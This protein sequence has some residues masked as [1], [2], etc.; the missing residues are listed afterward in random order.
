MA[1]DTFD[2]PIPPSPGTKRK[3]R[4]RLLEVEFGDGY[5]QTTR[6]GLNHIRRTLSL[7]WEL[8]TP[9]QAAEITDFLEE[10]GGDIPF[11]YQPSDDPAPLQWRCKDW[12]D[13][14][15]KGGWR[16]VKATFEQDFSLVE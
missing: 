16:K 15:G 11:L 7:E 2:P 1:L 8:L 6:D 9:T 12:D 5:T 3:P 13:T 10:K 14:N 4:V